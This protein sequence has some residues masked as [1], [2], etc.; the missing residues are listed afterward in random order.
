MRRRA[1][2]VG[3]E[4][5]GRFTSYHRGAQIFFSILARPRLAKCEQLGRDSIDVC[6]ASALHPPPLAPLGAYMTGEWLRAANGERLRGIPL[7]M[8]QSANAL[9]GRAHSL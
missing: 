7:P 8:V 1:V 9:S 2:V 3:G 5:V 4:A 6:H